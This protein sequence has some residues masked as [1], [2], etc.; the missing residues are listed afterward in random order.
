MYDVEFS[1]GTVRE[2]SANLIAQNMISQA[3][4]D[5]FSKTMMEGIVDYR[6]EESALSERDARIV[7]RRGQSRMRKTTQGWRLLVRWRD[8]NESWVHLKDLKDSHPVE[9]AEFAVARGIDREPAFAWWVP[10]TLRR[11]S[12]ILGA[13]KTRL[14]RVTHKYGI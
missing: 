4:D 6:K 1:D 14:Q 8:G 5:G 7:M 10:H 3:D 13:L 11:R 12:A 2:Y 9:T